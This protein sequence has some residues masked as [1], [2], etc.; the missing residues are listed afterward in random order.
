MENQTNFEK[1]DVI[2]GNRI[3]QLREKRSLTQRKLAELVLVSS[4]SITRLE[5]GKSMVSVFTMMKIAEIL[6]VSMA[7]IL[8]GTDQSIEQELVTLAMKLSQCPIKQRKKLIQSFEDIAD[9]FLEI[10]LQGH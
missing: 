4:S 2:I 9:N 8:K 5:S 6:N 7:D 1:G 10:N 3:K